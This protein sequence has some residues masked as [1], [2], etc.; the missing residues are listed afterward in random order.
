MEKVSLETMNQN[1]I[2][3]IRIVE[4]M[5]ED[6]ED[7]FLTAEEEIAVDKAREELKVGETFSLKDIE[8]MRK[9]A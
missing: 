9:N 7:I 8:D 4:Q 5:K 2:N 6:L 3:L 1:L